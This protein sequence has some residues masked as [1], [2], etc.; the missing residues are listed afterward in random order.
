MS[1]E[2]PWGDVNRHSPV[3]QTSGVHDPDL[4]GTVNQDS[5]VRRRKQRVRKLILWIG[6]PFLSLILLSELVN[7]VLRSRDPT[8][9]S[10][11]KGVQTA[12]KNLSTL[13]PHDE[14][15]P[16]ITPSASPALSAPSST[17]TLAPPPEPLTGVR[18]TIVGPTEVHIS[19]DQP[20]LIGPDAPLIDISGPGLIT[21]LTTYAVIKGLTP[22]SSYE[23]TL[24][25]RGLG[26][27]SL[28]V[29]VV[30]STPSSP[31]SEAAEPEYDDPAAGAAADNRSGGAGVGLR[32][33]TCGNAAAAGVPLPITAL[34]QPE[35]YYA[36][37]QLDRD[38]DG[39]ACES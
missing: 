34:G 14:S 28:P 1:A 11:S 25:R 7:V 22:E 8:Q 2:D 5:E 13:M 35:I 16:P 10:A 38:G 36:N 6:I 23:Y 32:Y 20:A 3:A 15:T 18:A 9:T 26:G 30:L 17:P 19:W 33:R 29:T 24:V 39:V 31:A 27:D 37:P 21:I 12:V 4:F